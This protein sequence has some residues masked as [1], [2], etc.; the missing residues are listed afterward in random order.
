MVFDG[1]RTYTGNTLRSFWWKSVER[2]DLPRIHGT[3]WRPEKALSFTQPLD[4]EAAKNEVLRFI[5]ERYD[6]HMQVVS[7]AWEHLADDGLGETFDGESWQEFSNR[8]C[9]TIEKGLT[10]RLDSIGL[11]HL[12]VIAIS[13]PL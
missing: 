9:E 3:K 7:A 5:I 2:S 11:G 1:L 4:A 13:Q 12:S 10:A 8:L 6:G